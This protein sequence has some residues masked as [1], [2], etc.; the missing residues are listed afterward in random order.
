MPGHDRIN[1]PLSVP[2]LAIIGEEDPWCEAKR[3]EHCG[4]VDGDRA[5]AISLVLPGNGHTIISSP[6]V[7]NAER[8]KR[9]VLEF[10]EEN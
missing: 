8:A 7:D 2:I 3:G 6:I 9:A 4:Q 10:L 1:A 5:K